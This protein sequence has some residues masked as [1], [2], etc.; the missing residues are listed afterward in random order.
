MADPLP[1]DLVARALGHAQAALRLAESGEWTQAAQ[2]EVLCREAVE[3]LAAMAGEADAGALLAGLTEIREQHA[4]LLALA[5]SHRDRLAS[6]LRESVRGRA[7]AL[8]Y[9][10]NG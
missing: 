1:G 10:E 2:Y 7:A 3:S 4:R 9:Q 5:E 8:A 6:A